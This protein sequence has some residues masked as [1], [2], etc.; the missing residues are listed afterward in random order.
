MNSSLKMALLGLFLFAS[1]GVF[2]QTW[3]EKYST[4]EFKVS[5][6]SVDCNGEPA[7]ILKV[8]STASNMVVPVF[9]VKYSHG[10]VSIDQKAE[11]NMLEPG[12][13][14]EAECGMTNILYEDMIIPLPGGHS[15]DLSK[16]SI[17]KLY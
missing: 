9:R 7:I 8:A 6:A 4:P 11:V 14:L 17:G 3:T 15:V 2:A 16:F 5:V 12:K 13:T 10:A 1:S